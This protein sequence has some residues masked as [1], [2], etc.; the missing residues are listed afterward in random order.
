MRFSRVVPTDRDVLG[1]VPISPRQL[2]SASYLGLP[3]PGVSAL[4]A[5]PGSATLL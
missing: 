5:I 2:R 4:P 1:R 3:G